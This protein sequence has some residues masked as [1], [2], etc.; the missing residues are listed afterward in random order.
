MKEAL[1]SLRELVQAKEGMETDLIETN[2]TIYNTRVKAVELIYNARKSVKY[3]GWRAFPVLPKNDKI[4]IIYAAEQHAKT[5]YPDELEVITE[6]NDSVIL[7]ENGFPDNIYMSYKDGSLQ[8]IYYSYDTC[9]NYI[10][11]AIYRN[12]YHVEQ[13]VY[14]IKKVTQ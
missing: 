7:A 11:N 9:M 8:A 3:Q 12:D 13:W 1:E 5:V 2:K 14:R 10:R 4:Y 6:P